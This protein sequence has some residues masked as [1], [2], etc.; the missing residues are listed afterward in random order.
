MRAVVNVIFCL[1]YYA[2]EM[3]SKQ[4]ICTHPVL[5]FHLPMFKYSEKII[6]SFIESDTEH[7]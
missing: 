5:T 7:P 6:L 2:N 1:Y 3:L 4:Q